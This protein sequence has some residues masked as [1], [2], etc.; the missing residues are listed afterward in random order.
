MFWW[1]SSLLKL[2]GSLQCLFSWVL[3]LIHSN[4]YSS[5]NRNKD[6][7]IWKLYKL[8]RALPFVYRSILSESPYIFSDAVLK[9]KSTDKHDYTAWLIRNNW[10]SLLF[11]PLKPIL[12]RLLKQQIDLTLGCARVL[13]A[14]FF[15]EHHLTIIFISVKY[16]SWLYH[17][18]R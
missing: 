12:R 13:C 7:L 3:V 2:K 15:K 10:L 17:L 4:L 18:S 9:M 11:S 14:L 16:H 5:D 6:L 1:N 8:L